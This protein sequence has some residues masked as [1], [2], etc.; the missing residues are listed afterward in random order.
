M[1]IEMR[2]IPKNDNLFGICSRKH[3]AVIVVNRNVHD[4]AIGTA[5]EISEFCRA[6][7]YNRLPL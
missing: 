5:N 1:P 7:T 2:A 4:C 3:R 6:Y